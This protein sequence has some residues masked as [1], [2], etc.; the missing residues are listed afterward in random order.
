MLG[1]IKP[2][3]VIVALIVVGLS[4]ASGIRTVTSS[5]HDWQPSTRMCLGCPAGQVVDSDML[6][7]RCNI[8]GKWNW[9]ASTPPVTS[10][11]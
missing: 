4:L 6:A 3:T 11:P 1:L 9:T 10:T 8:C 2:L 5:P 7:W